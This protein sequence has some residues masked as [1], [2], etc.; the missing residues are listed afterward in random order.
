VAFFLDVVLQWL[1]PQALRRSAAGYSINKAFIGRSGHPVVMPGISKL[2][3]LLVV[4]AS[5]EVLSTASATRENNCFSWEVS[6]GG[7]LV[8]VLHGRKA[9]PP[10]SSGGDGCFRPPASGLHQP[11]GKFATSEALR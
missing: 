2:L 5:S 10:P 7:E 9:T 11:P 6:Y 1:E 3:P 4:E 8:G